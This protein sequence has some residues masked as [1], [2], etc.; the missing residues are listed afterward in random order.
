MAVRAEDRAGTTEQQPKIVVYLS[1]RRYCRSRIP[2]EAALLDSNCRG[3]TAYGIQVRL[4]HPFEKLTDVRRKTFDISALTLGI[5]RVEGEAG[6]PAPGW[7][8]NDGDLP[9]RNRNVYI[10]EIMCTDSLENEG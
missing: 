1:H 6:L 4:F 10:L 2:A 3:Y 8:G 9:L 7:T 5:N